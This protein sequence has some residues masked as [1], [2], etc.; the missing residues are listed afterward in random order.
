MILQA[1]AA[2]CGIACLAMVAAAYGQRHTLSDLRRKFSASLKG[3][4]LKSVMDMA[5][6]LGMV[7]RPLRLEVDELPSLKPP[8]VLHWNLAHYVVL[9]KAWNGPGGVWAII[10]DPARGVRKVAPA[11]IGRS[12]TGVALELTPTPAFT[13]KKH[14]ERVRL[15]DM[16][17]T[18]KGLKG[19]VIQLFLLALVVQVIGVFSPMLNQLII[20]DAISKGDVDL[21]TTIGMG[22]VILLLIQ[23]GIGLLQG[24]VGMYLGTQLSFQ[25]QSN[26]LRHALRLP[27][28]WFEKR[29]IG[30]IMSRFSSLGPVQSFLTSVPIGATLNVIMLL[31]GGTMAVLYSPLLFGC[32]VATMLIPLI[33]QAVTFPWVRRKTDEGISLSAVAS[34]T[35]METLRGARTFKLFGK[36]RERVSQWQNDTAA[37]VNNSVT[38]QRVGLWGGAGLGIVTG[39]QGVAVWWLGAKQVI[40]GTMSLGM[41]MAFQSY[42][43]QFSGALKGLIGLFFRWKMLE[44]HLERLADVVHEDP[45]VGVDEPIQEGRLFE[46]RIGA[47]KLSFR[48]ATHEPLVFKDASFSIDPGQFVAIIGPS[49]GGKT[50]LMKVLL[51][52]LDPTE[53]E[54]KVE[55][56]GLKNFG[57][58]TFRHRIGAVLQDDR[59]LAGTI[60]DNVS[61]FDADLDMAKVEECLAKAC[62]LDDILKMPMGTMTLVGDL[63]STL[64]GGQQQRVLLA[65]ALYREPTILFLDEGTANLDPETEARVSETLR[66]LS[67]TRIFVAHREAAIAGADR[68]LLVAGGTVT[69]MT[70]MGRLSKST[71][72]S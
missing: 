23:T 55:G 32:V 24:F 8:C 17:S 70:E 71:E 4:T 30:D 37:S 46:G 48:Y 12:F 56:V 21:L 47:E 34:T 7:G 63:G 43:G 36:E 62:V 35:F 59:L 39:L 49:G 61:F 72:L 9:K 27:V 64:S 69:D 3:T 2:E 60:A 14:I 50:T 10:H 68:T 52:L 25:M 22:M 51:G 5:D 66:G 31:V 42:A 1:E 33:V 28:A 57:V 54:V 26:L 11:E 58:R 16:W 40:D 18:L 67:C 20:D 38:M 44:L 19:P 29:H 6:G 45:E 53:G 15:T 41:L 65:R 13:K